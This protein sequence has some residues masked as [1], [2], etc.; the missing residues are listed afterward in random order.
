[1][2]PYG[3]G[4]H[5][6][7]DDRS[8][9]FDAG[10]ALA[11]KQTELKTRI[12]LRGG[13]VLDQGTEDIAPCFA[14]ANFLNMKPAWRSGFEL[15]QADDALA[16]LGISNLETAKHAKQL[17]YITRYEHAFN[18]IDVLGA[19]MHSPIIMGTDWTES[20]FELDEL[21]YAHPEGDVIGGHSFVAYG[22]HMRKQYV[23]CL[24]SWGRDW[25]VRGTFKL[26]F[27]DLLA[28][29]EAG[30]DAVVPVPSVSRAGVQ[31]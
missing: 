27:A 14:M 3:L 22:T 29:F 18:F 24:S 8:L 26:S 6:E 13:L 9:R 20:M 21:G 12:W 28:L 2:T 15:L 30:G 10:P 16:M 23:N 1:M 5:R 31:E 25:G 7:H 19:I 11:L 4:R 17:G